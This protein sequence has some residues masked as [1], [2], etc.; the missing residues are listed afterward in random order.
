MTTNVSRP[1]SFVLAGALAGVLAAGLTAPAQALPDAPAPAPASSS[2]S[3]TVGFGLSFS[4]GGDAAVDTGIGV[5]VFSDDR[6][7]RGAA[8]LGV[9]CMLMSQRWR[10]TIGAAYMRSNGYIAVDL[11]IGLTDGAVDFGA[12]LGGVNTRSA[13]AAAPPPPGP[14]GDGLSGVAAEF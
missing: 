7:N 11:G 1:L 5:R 8:S 9:D 12:S 13:P 4:F 6:S 10:G 3:P 2:S 14:G